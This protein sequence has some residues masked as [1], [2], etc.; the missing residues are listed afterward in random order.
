MNSELYAFV[1]ESLRSGIEREA[2]RDALLEARWPADEVNGA[3]AAFAE[4]DFP[5]PVPRPRPYLQAREAFLYLVSFITLYVT[6]F[7]FG[8]L[9]FGFID[10]AFPDRLERGREVFSDTMARA[11]ASIV[12]AFPI[13]LFFMWRIR[14][15]AAKD[16][17]QRQSRIR[18]WLTYL[19][20]IIAAGIIIGDLIAL[21]SEFLLGDL[22]ARFAL[23]GLT[24][25]AVTGVI[26][27]YYFWEL[28]QGE[29]VEE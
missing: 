23:K 5:V 22:S 19:T 8:I 3:L 2:I 12:I 26:F 13:Y 27:G 7:S 16:P 28:R 4:V 6:A 25:L 10:F 24:V 20:L 21:L 29:V 18:K 9:V 14:E 17:E 11:I 15:N 1:K